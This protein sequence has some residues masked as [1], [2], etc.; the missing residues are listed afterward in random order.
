MAAMVVALKYPWSKAPA[1]GLPR[2]G[3]MVRQGAGHNQETV[4]FHGGLRIVML[5][6]AIVG[7]VFHDA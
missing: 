3:G 5:S 2:A 4:L 1:L 6:K 7:A